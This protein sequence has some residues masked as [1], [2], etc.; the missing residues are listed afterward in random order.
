VQDGGVEG[1]GYGDVRTA[2][3]GVG[4]GRASAV[5]H[6]PAEPVHGPG[7]ARDQPVA[8]VL[9]PSGRHIRLQLLLQHDAEPAQHPPGLHQQCHQGAWEVRGAGAEAQEPPVRK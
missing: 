9:H 7:H 6:Q 2:G 3:V 5:Q 4:R 1:D 8:A